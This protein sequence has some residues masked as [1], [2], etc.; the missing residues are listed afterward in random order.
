M[1]IR[2]ATPDDSPAL[3]HILVRGW[4]ESY[5][6]I[7]D[8]DWLDALDENEYRAQWQKWFADENWQ[9]LI[10]HDDDGTAAGFAGFGKL[11]T[12]PPGSSP[13]RPLYSAELYAIYIL[14]E[15]WRQGLGTKLVRDA[16]AQLVT[17]K[18]K[19]LCLWTMEKNKQAIDFY[20]HLGGE[21]CGKKEVQI[22][23]T[24]AREVCFGWRDTAPLLP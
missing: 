22:G 10:A 5:K 19:S 14:P 6:H 16:A 7:I 24:S 11:K 12:P 17:M 23:P 21:R 3:A 15:F 2:S 1:E 9:V 8:Q 4:Q 20:K 13:I 18:H